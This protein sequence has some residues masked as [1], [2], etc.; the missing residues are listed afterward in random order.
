MKK[1]AL[2]ALLLLPILSYAE[3]YKS[4][5]EHGNVVYTDIAPEKDANAVELPE[6]NIVETGRVQPK[7]SGDKR[8][9]KTPEN[10][11]RQI[12]YSEL[13]IIQPG[14]DETIRDNA[15]NVIISVHLTPRLFAEQGHQ[16][17]I[18]MDGQMINNGTSN[19]VRLENIDRGTHNV[20]A[21]ITDDQGQELA[22]ANG[23]TFHLKRATAGN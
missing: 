6:L 3:I 8:K 23:I 13:A 18:E 9:H 12:N 16:L 22:T 2:L 7:S 21:Y 4:R 5:D 17:I 19:T 1:L 20:T 11:A 14:N 10:D 15:G